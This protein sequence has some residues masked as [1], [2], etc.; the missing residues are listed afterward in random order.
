MMDGERKSIVIVM[1]IAIFAIVIVTCFLTWVDHA[2]KANFVRNGYSQVMVPGHNAPV[3][4]K[5]GVGSDSSRADV[6]H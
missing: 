4:Q 1:A 2:N 6:Q 3:W 5:M